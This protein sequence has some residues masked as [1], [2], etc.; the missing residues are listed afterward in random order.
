MELCKKKNGAPLRFT[1]KSWKRETVPRA[2][3]GTQTRMGESRQA[4]CTAPPPHD[5]TALCE[6]RRQDGQLGSASISALFPF[7]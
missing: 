2:K 4:Q 5:K 7:Q 3:R 1:Q 6:R